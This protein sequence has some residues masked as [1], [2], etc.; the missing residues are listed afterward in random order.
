MNRFK[1]MA[2]LGVALLTI[3]GA[4]LYA[5]SGSVARGST[6]RGNVA[7]LSRSSTAP[8]RI[9][10]ETS[11]TR[12]FRSYGELKGGAS[13]VVLGT[14]NAQQVSSTAGRTGMAWTDTTVRVDQVLF[15]R[16]ANTPQTV[17]VRQAGGIAGNAQVVA[18]D[19]PPMTI[20]ERYLLFL[21][22]DVLDPSKYYIVGAHQGGFHVGTD[23]AV[24]SLAQD[25]AGTGLPIHDVPLDQVIQLI[26]VAPDI[27]PTS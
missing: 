7:P 11:L 6:A 27:K 20:G 14:A 3:G 10:V 15:Q 5:H 26:K 13:L 25:A 19:I 16:D 2:M 23:N 8:Q 22:P 9:T 17:V 21:V 1:Q 24:N 18:D 12:L 4:G